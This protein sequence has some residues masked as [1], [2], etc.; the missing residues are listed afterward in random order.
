MRFR[1]AARISHHH[2]ET[3]CHM[4]TENKKLRNGCEKITG[5][6]GIIQEVIRKMEE[7]N[8]LPDDTEE[9]AVIKARKYDEIE[10]LIDSGDRR[11][12][13]IEN[14]RFNDADDTEKTPE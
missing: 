8:N 3:R 14:I 5:M 1:D 2:K 6:C 10:A 13:E 9:E 11:M 4:N 7:F 12:E